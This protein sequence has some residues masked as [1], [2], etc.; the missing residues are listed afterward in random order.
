MHC[1]DLK[2]NYLV[3]IVLCSVVLLYAFD[4]T[5][6]SVGWSVMR[7]KVAYIYV[8]VIALLYSTV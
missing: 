3:I 6:S 4:T 5:I 8:S 1:G 2:I 7:G